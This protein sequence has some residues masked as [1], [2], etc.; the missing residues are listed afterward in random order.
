MDIGTIE[1]I[2]ETDEAA[3]RR[4]NLTSGGSGSKGGGGRDPGGGGD[5]SDSDADNPE[6]F[7]P[8]R[9]RVFT[10]FLL[11]VVLMTFGALAAAYIVLVTDRAAEWRPFDLPLQVWFSTAII[12][13]SS[14]VY[15]FAKVAI[16]R[17]EQRRS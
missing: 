15:H 11:I 14:F 3:A 16:D 1:T 4:T 6:I 2:D 9:S 10:A 17:E 12:V 7:T 8:H 5:R 13:A